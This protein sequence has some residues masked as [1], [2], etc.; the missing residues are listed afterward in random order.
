MVSLAQASSGSRM[1]SFF[2]R[3]D[4]EW[5]RYTVTFQANVE[6]ISDIK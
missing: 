2:G 6:N 3:S 1:R 4:D 5:E